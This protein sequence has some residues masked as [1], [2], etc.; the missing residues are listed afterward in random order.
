MIRM[1]MLSPYMYP[2]NDSLPAQTPPLPPPPPSPPPPVSSAPFTAITCVCV[3]T[4]SALEVRAWDHFV[5]SS[6]TEAHTQPFTV[7]NCSPA[8]KPS[9]ALVAG[10]LHLDALQ[11]RSGRIGNIPSPLHLPFTAF[12]FPL[13]P[14]FPLPISLYPLL[15]P[16]LPG[17]LCSYLLSP[18]PSPFFLPIPL[19]PPPP[20][21]FNLI[22]FYPVIRACW[23]GCGVTLRIA[24]LLL[25]GF[26]VAV[27]LQ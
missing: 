21:H 19:T 8:W 7:C 11:L 6:F 16:S 9:E 5:L 20:L 13:P 14:P 1:S 24:R 17:L 4:L 22:L 15:S 18:P 26:E 27:N 10:F 3:I 2:H 23:D 25:H 12:S